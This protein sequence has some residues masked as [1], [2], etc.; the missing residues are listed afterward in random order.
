MEIFI[1]TTIIF[2]YT[3]GVVFI[4]AR[5]VYYPRKG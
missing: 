4:M 3:I 5:F 2:W 1:E